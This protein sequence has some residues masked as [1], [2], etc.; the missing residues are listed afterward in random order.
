MV[1][2]PRSARTRTSGRTTSGGSARTTSAAGGWARPSAAK[3]GA[4]AVTEP[5]AGSDVGGIQT[6]ADREGE[7]WRLTGEKTFIT[8]GSIADFAVVAAKSDPAAGDRGITL[9]VVDS[10]LDGYSASRG[11][12]RSD[13]GRPTQARS[14]R[15]LRV[16][17]DAHSATRTTGSGTNHA[18]LQWERLAMALGAVAGA[19]AALALAMTYAR[20]GRRSAG[21]WRRSRPGGTGSPTWPPQIE[22][23]RS[24]TYGALY[25]RW[26]AGEDATARGLDGEVVPTELAWRG[27]RQALQAHGGYGYMMEYPVQRAW[28][29]AR[30]GPIGGG[31]TEMMKEIIGR[32]HG[33]VR[34]RRPP[35]RPAVHDDQR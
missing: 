8:N 19:E 22:A 27:G 29:D 7:T 10:T 14:L 15:R 11:C 26:C 9:F 17:G 18:N 5:G 33:P 34:R 6:R 21:R 23:A 35:G 2:S 16:A 20:N 3:V 24:L 4:L 32:L 30:L 25:G 13:G 31:T 12:R 28:R 1:S